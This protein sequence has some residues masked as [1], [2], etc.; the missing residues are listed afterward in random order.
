MG[1][2]SVWHWMIITIILCA[3]VAPF[4]MIFKRTG[5][6]PV[7]SILAVIPGAILIFIWIMA[8]KRWP[9]DTAK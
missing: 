7:L 3:I 1:S 6:P 4:W 9:Q 8:L 5:I 2:F